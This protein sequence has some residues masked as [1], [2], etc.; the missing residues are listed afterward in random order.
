MIFTG[1][2]PEGAAPDM[3]PKIG[4]EGFASCADGGYVVCKAAGV[5]PDAVIG[6]FDSLSGEQIEEIHNL[7]VEC[8][9]HPREKD[10][11]DT[12]LCVKHGLAKGYDR[13]VIV[14]GIGGD[15]GHTMANIQTLS[16]LTDMGCAAEIVTDRDRL[17]IGGERS[18]SSFAGRPGAKFSVFSYAE[19]STGVCITNA[20][21]EL[22]DAVL[23]H[24]YPV[25][26]SNEFV[27]TEPVRVSVRSG[28]LLIVTER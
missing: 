2:W 8:I 17:F 20:L 13:F 12:M 25:G 19:R 6:D 24:S 28:R 1:L 9:K 26:V 5:M 11:T 22:S 15:F 10:E 7:G 16:F 18:A 23:T 3:I 14:G 4:P 21:Y 27:N